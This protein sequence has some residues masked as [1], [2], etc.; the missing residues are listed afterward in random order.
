MSTNTVLHQLPDIDARLELLA[1]L[2]DG[3]LDG[4]GERLDPDRLHE[5][6]ELLERMTSS[7]GLPP[8]YLYPTSEGNIQAE[9]T[10]GN[11]EVSL[12]FQV[13]HGAVVGMAVNVETDADDEIEIS[14][15]S[16]GAV[17]QLGDFVMRFFAG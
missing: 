6:G 13:S 7:R 17:R 11:W 1:G 16:E 9:W 10:F 12:T 15:N 3:W 4:E 8:P 14:L 5:I 2:E